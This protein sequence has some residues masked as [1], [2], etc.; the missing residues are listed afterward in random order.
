MELRQYQKRAVDEVITEIQMFDSTNV[1]IE[2]PTGSGKSLIISELC[3]R[4]DGKIIILV[5]I[6][7]LVTQISSHLV[8]LNVEH[9]I[10]KAGR[11]DEYDENSRVHII[12]SQTY[13]AR[14][15]VLN[16]SADYIIQDERHKEYLT[17]RTNAVV[18]H[19]KPKCIIGLTA[20]P[21]DNA[22][23]CLENASIIKTATI[24]QLESQ[25]FLAP[26][27]YY[28]PRWAA[29]LDFSDLKMSGSDY[30]G[31]SIDD[32]FN[33]S[34]YM[35]LI[36]ESMNQMRAKDKKTI[37]FCN[38]IEHAENV[39]NFL[40]KDGYLVGCVHSKKSDKDNNA[41]LEAFKV[42]NSAN[43]NLI[44]NSPIKCLVSV[45]KLNTGFDVRDIN[46]G[47]M[48]RPTKVR[49][50][51]IQSIGRIT[52]IA[53]DKKYAEFLDL[54]G[55]VKEHGFHDEDYF[56]PEKGNKKDLLAAKALAEAA[57]IEFIVKEEPTEITRKDVNLFVEEL[58]RKSKRISSMNNIELKA[59][60][61]QSSDVRQIVEVALEI[62]KRMRQVNYKKEIIEYICLNWDIAFETY[63]EYKTRWIKSMKTRAK[64]IVNEGKKLASLKYFIGFLV[65]N[66]KDFYGV[67]IDY[68][69]TGEDLEALKDVSCYDGYVDVEYDLPF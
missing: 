65:E 31:S 57:E 28:V 23:Y 43:N 68:V 53:S 62:N 16:I 30:S 58:K 25:E 46:L 29:K 61:E 40:L 12:M 2:A 13:Y 15:D 17:D 51:Y 44:D 50:L 19:M 11:E 64:N 67:P 36:V 20:T 3:K 42:S 63:P 1:I 8:E 32:K 5:N 26:V 47:V 48:L 6:T 69:A 55:V 35:E 39:T 14:Q 56:P 34:Q 49:S 18:N 10:L 27:K 24:K 22:G 60:F 37:V 54:C 66:Q 33:T 45:S 7:S 21:F 41:I 59:I 52:R 38:S 4:L 9:S